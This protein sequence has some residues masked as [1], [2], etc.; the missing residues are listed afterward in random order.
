[1]KISQLALF[2]Q[3]K[4]MWTLSDEHGWNWVDLNTSETLPIEESIDQ[5]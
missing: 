2:L 4:M 1:M 3:L 5:N